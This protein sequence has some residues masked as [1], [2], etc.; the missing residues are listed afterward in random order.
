[1]DDD[2]RHPMGRFTYFLTRVLA[3]A[4]PETTYQT[5]FERLQAQMAQRFPDQVPSIEGDTH[6]RVMDGT[7]VRSVHFPRVYIDQDREAVLRAGMV[8]GMTVGSE[9]ELHRYGVARPTPATRLATAV[10]A[11]VGVTE[12][13]LRLTGRRRGFR[14]QELQGAVAVETRHHYGPHRLKVTAAPFRAL[15]HGESIVTMLKN[16]DAVELLAGGGTPDVRLLWI[17][18]AEAAGR[19][20]SRRVERPEAGRIP[21][22]VRS[23][24]GVVLEA[25]TGSAADGGAIRGALRREAIYRAARLLDNARPG[26]PVGVEMRIIPALTRTAGTES[27]WR[28]DRPWPSSRRALR[29]GDAFTLEVRNTG[30]Y[31]V[32]ISVLDLQSDGR[33]GVLWPPARTPVTHRL[34]R[35]QRTW[36]KLWTNSYRRPWPFRVTKPYGTEL[37]KVVATLQKLDLSGL[38]TRG[39]ADTPLEQLWQAALTGTRGPDRADPKDWGTATCVLQAEAGA[40]QGSAPVAGDTLPP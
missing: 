13:T 1:M 20:V 3:A 25:L 7:A 14:W 33:V 28:Q 21:A 24:D 27:E 35:E 36:H 4:G 16:L 23:S 19:Q 39:E 17:T 34:P 31:D 18:A 2:G 22:V 12:S 30:E 38:A 9:L 8:H 5:A 15:P 6:R 26:N 29:E 11:L 32:W 37:L 10:V 40:H